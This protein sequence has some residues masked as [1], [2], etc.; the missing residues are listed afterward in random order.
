VNS[1]SAKTQTPESQTNAAS[2]ETDRRMM[3]TRSDFKKYSGDSIF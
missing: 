2:R 3:F 1:R